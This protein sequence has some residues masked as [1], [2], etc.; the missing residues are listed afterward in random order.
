MKNVLLAVLLLLP[1]GAM[2]QEDYSW[3]SYWSVTSVD[4]MDGR[5]DDYIADLKKNW[6]RSLEMQ[7]K[8]GHVLSYRMF[9]NADKR[10]GEPDLWLFV[11]HKSAGSAYDLPYDYWE[12]MADKLWGSTEKGD[13]ANVKRGELRTIMSS[14]L[15][16]EFD[17]K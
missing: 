12:K 10:M 17:F 11:E 6:R 9:A 4:T 2:A 15:L 14:T 13:K 7:K 8:D 5:F 1:L 16:R 3:G